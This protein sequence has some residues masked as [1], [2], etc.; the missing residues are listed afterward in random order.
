MED[1][2]EDLEHI[3][4]EDQAS[5]NILDYIEKHGSAD[6]MSSLIE[7]QGSRMLLQ[8]ADMASMME[9]MVR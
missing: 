8:M 6:W 4:D 7:G 1:L 2:K 3:E 9:I 5:L